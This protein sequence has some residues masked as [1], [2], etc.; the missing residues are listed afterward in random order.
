[1]VITCQQIY[2]LQ[3][4]TQYWKRMFGREHKF[5]QSS[6]LKNLMGELVDVIA[7]GQLFS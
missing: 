4:S 1:M 6:D 2:F 7:D 3:M 5:R